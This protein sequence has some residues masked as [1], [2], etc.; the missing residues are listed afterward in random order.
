MT[1]CEEKVR[2]TALRDEI[3]A[4]LTLNI[5]YTCYAIDNFILISLS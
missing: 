5:Y 1:E 4:A 3:P 2:E